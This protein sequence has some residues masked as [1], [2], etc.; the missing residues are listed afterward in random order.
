MTIQNELLAFELGYIAHEKGKNL[1]QA[2]ADQFPET[3]KTSEPLR[4]VW[5][6]GGMMGWHYKLMQGDKYVGNFYP[7]TSDGIDMEEIISRL[8]PLEN[9]ND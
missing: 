8:A 5:N 3:S 1:Q 2:L 6:R 9:P 4:W 7:D